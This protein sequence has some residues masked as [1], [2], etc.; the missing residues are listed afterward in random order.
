MILES[1]KEYVQAQESIQKMDQA[2]LKALLKDVRENEE[3]DNYGN[4]WLELAIM[5]LLIDLEDE[6]DAWLEI[7]SLQNYIIKHLINKEDKKE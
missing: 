5:W 6:R 3:S 2:Q 1:R 7:K 4:C